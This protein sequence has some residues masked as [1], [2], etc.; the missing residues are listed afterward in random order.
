MDSSYDREVVKA[1]GRLG[2]EVKPRDVQICLRQMFEK[3]TEYVNRYDLRADL[4]L[5][6]FCRRFSCGNTLATALKPRAF[7]ALVTRVRMGRMKTYR[8]RN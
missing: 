3:A 8:W 2:V 7:T 1:F 5:V 4:T 6:Q